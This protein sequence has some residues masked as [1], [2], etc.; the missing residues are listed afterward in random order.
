[1]GNSLFQLCG[2]C[3]FEATSS[4]TVS[5][6]AILCNDRSCKLT[7]VQRRRKPFTQLKIVGHAP[8]SHFLFNLYVRP[9]SAV[10][11]VN[12]TSE[13]IRAALRVLRLLHAFLQTLYHRADLQMP[14]PLCSWISDRSNL[15][16]PV[17]TAAQAQTQ[18]T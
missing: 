13:K 11:R 4:T 12:F 2:E 18:G 14:P 1:M 17:S 3:S 5:S 7:L 16:P 8:D 9:V 15:P 6:V 10:L